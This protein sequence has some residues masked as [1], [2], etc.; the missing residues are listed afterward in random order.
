MRAKRY[1]VTRGP[2]DRGCY[3]RQST[4]YARAGGDSPSLCIPRHSMPLQSFSRDGTERGIDV[5]AS[6][7]V[8]TVRQRRV[9][10]LVSHGTYI[11]R[12][13]RTRDTSDKR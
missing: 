10:K 4:S 8:D 2:T 11:S 9:R 1:L 6:T 3:A 5:D 7:L 12:D 13:E